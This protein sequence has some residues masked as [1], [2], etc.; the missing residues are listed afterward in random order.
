MQT[1]YSKLCALCKH[2]IDREDDLGSTLQARCALTGKYTNHESTCVHHEH[3]Y[4]DDFFFTDIND[5]D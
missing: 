1:D 3:M 4:T 2:F 5:D